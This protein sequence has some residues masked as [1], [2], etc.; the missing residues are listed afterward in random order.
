MLLQ[1]SIRNYAII[2]ELSF[3]PDAGL[4]ILTG[5]TGAGKSIMLGALSLILGERADSSVLIN[6]AEKCI[7]EALFEV[8]TN[9]RF[10]AALRDEEIDDEAECII[11]REISASGKSRAFVN[12]TPV[13]LQI[14]NHLTSMLVD[15]HQQFDHLALQDDSF[16]LDVL[17]AVAK[18][19]SIR[20]DYQSRYQSLRRV[21]AEIDRLQ[22]E[23]SQRQK[24]ADYKQY[25]LQEL[26]E[27]A[28]KPNEIEDADAQL[29]TLA[30][31][32]RI[33]M[34]LGATR[35]FLTEGEQPLLQG[36]KRAAQQIQGVSEW[37]PASVALAER[38]NSAF[39]ELKDISD[40][41]EHLEGDL[42]LDGNLMQSLQ[43][44]VDL[45]YKLLKK[46]GLNDTQ[47][48]LNLQ[49]ELKKEAK[50]A[51]ELSGKLEELLVQKENLRGDLNKTGLSLSEKRQ[52]VAPG[53]AAEVTRLLAL[54]GMPNARFD[55]RLK[56][57]EEPG[58]FGFDEVSF[59]LDANKSGQFLPLHKAA[60]GGEMS[61]I[62]LSIKSLTAQAVA[63]PTL[64]FDEVDTGISGEAAK[65][66]G[67]LL[68]SLSHFHQ[69]ICIT[70][71]PQ[72]AAR[73]TRHFFVYKD[74][75]EMGRIRTKLR[76][77]EG[78]ERI[79]A[80]ARMIGG[81][82]PGMAAMEHARGLVNYQ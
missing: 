53:I 66:V 43:E 38:L 51:G 57:N 72:V 17:D 67:M 20:K 64:I 40:E 62:M 7:V 14:L 13:T 68:Q 61:R 27:A 23:E 28:F 48:L 46:H 35:E 59:L 5:E 73:G 22:K 25:L 77:L 9:E 6:K 37:L 32:E 44:R 41:V 10:R 21:E 30:H 36:L 12:D 63:L 56:V 75:A 24:E 26:D 39:F 70:H 76:S 1:L 50:A 78:E 52:E 33:Q 34:V 55:I 45:G 8:K 11:R 65:Q 58:T 2:D 47:G 71:Q 18:T 79:Q 3:Q 49:E 82:E 4:S 69:V 81:E 60:S 80:I 15:L 16:Q 74:G 19:D 29:K 54:V 31:A 42:V